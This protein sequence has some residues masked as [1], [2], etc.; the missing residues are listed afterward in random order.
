M[1]RSL[2]FEVDKVDFRLLHHTQVQ[3]VDV[4]VLVNV[5]SMTV[6]SLVERASGVQIAEIKVNTS[7][8][9]RDYK[10]RTTSHDLVFTEILPSTSGGVRT[11]GIGQGVCLEGKCVYNT[12]RFLHVSFPSHPLIYFRC[13]MNVL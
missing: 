9:A 5:A 2:S 13:R 7:P 11:N 8:S 10:R 12:S 3:P 4:D 1:N 6:F